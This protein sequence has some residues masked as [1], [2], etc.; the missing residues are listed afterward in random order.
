MY[1]LA[2]ALCFFVLAIRG[3]VPV[4]DG[5]AV[6][7]DA[8]FI[9]FIKGNDWTF[10]EFYAPW[11]GHCKSLAPIFISTAASLKE[12]N[13]NVVLAKVDCTQQKQICSEVQGYPTLKLYSKTGDKPFDY[14]GERTEEV[15][16]AFLNKKTGPPSTRIT[17]SEQLSSFLEGARSKVVAY[18]DESDPEHS[19]WEDIARNQ[20][21]ELFAF[22]HVDSSVSN[23]KPRRTIELTAQG[24]DTV[25]YT[26]ETFNSNTIAEWISE[27]GFPLVETLS[28]EA[29][30]RATT[31]PTSKLLAAVFYDKDGEVPT[32]VEEVASQF[33]GTVIFT[34]SDSSQILERWGGSGTFLPSAVVLD[35]TS[36]Q[37]SLYTFDESG[38]ALSADSLKSFIQESIAGTYKSN[39]KSEPIPENDN[40]A[41]RT[42]VAKNFD[43]VIADPAYKVI[44]VEFYAPWCGHCK[45]LAPVLDELGKHF[46]ENKGVV[47]A[48]FDA[49]AN[50]V[51]K[52]IKV[53]GFPTILLFQNGK[54]HTYSGGHDLS[55]LTTFVEGFV[56]DSHDDL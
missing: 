43:E 5:I 46:Q 28:Q 45:K 11:C 39:I 18:I 30:N 6:L 9:E 25:T 12:A 53:E 22:A 1:F 16:T 40:A 15:I 8:N 20:A 19:V 35:F 34:T 23:A 36:A 41:V 52:D 4:E 49:T 54:F 29:W 21:F 31:H 38:V 51:R 27:H 55:S 47:I 3:E 32:Y 24:K 2:V 48:K 17:T 7:S 42:L 10:V 26:P 37:P 44:L 50:T 33:K 56:R 13:A 14:D